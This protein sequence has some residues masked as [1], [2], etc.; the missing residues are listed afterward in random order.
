MCK[1]TPMI[2]SLTGYQAQSIGFGKLF[3]DGC[4]KYC[5]KYTKIILD[6]T[7][8]CYLRRS[9]LKVINFEAYG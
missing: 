2:L 9:R 5:L 8:F 3:H 4:V 6:F 1:L 7:D